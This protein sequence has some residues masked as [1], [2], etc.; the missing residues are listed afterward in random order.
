MINLDTSNLKT[1]TFPDRVQKNILSKNIYQSLKD[2]SP[3]D[4]AFDKI[5]GR[6]DYIFHS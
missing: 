6:S 3:G 2:H 1:D 4:E 5:I